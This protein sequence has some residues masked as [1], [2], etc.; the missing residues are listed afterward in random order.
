MPED[1]LSPFEDQPRVKLD[2]YA[3]AAGPRLGVRGWLRWIWRQVTS[4]RVAMILLLF[5][6]LA[7]IP[8]SLLPQY[9]QDPVA[10]RA[11]VENNPGWGPV[12]HALGLLD[13]FAS[14]W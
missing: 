8:G 1:R 11:F 4:M 9:S 2:N 14:A 13:V 7:S 10:A 6:A 12:A 3:V 5:V